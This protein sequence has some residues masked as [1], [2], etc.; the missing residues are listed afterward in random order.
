MSSAW[1]VVLRL[2]AFRPWLALQALLTWMGVSLTPVAIGMASR[3]FFDALGAGAAN[4]YWLAALPLLIQCFRLLFTWINVPLNVLHRFSLNALL[5]RNLLERLLERPGAEPLP[6]APGEVLS[7]FRE[8]VDQVAGFPTIYQLFSGLGEAVTATVAISLM[9]SINAPVTLAAL[10]PLLGVVLVARMAGRL[11]ERYRGVNRAATGRV[12]AAITELFSMAQAIRL[13][14]TEAAASAHLDR[15]QDQRR[16][17]AVRDRLFEELLRSVY[18]NAGTLG[19]GLVVLLAAQAMQAGTFSVGDFA[20]FSALL[21]RISLFA[22]VVG[23]LLS[24]YRQVQVGL[25]R[26]AEL[27]P[28]LAPEALAA[29]SPIHVDGGRPVAPPP[30]PVRSEPLARLEVRELSCLHP[31]SGRGVAGIS[32]ALARGSLTVIA[33]RVGSGKSTLLRG[34]LGLLPRQAGELYWNG[35]A[36]DDP[37]AWFTPPRSAYTPQVPTL[38]SETVGANISQGWPAGTVQIE[39]AVHGAVLEQDLAEFEQGLETLV[40]PRGIRLSGG[41]VQRVAAARALLRSPDLLVVD[42]LSSALD[43]ETER[44]LWQRLR[45]RQGITCLAVSNR[46]AALEAADQILVLKDGR[47]EA[48]GRLPDLLSH[49]EE[50]RQ[51][52]AGEADRTA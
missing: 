50:F 8:D 40:G 22:G 52:W 10:L 49:S 48:V 13:A 3:A 26:L 7:R 1:R 15:L 18:F 9:L 19:T 37:A 24:R 42:D 29:H 30:A 6:R 38:F 28:G 27:V 51:L 12:T 21:G 31:G 20:L 47:L 36:L 11:V 2:I 45:E 33:G 34:L 16:S 25:G 17:A 46:R 4:L 32:F 44:L 23:D 43:L 39:A 35:R 14:G 41:Q 5:S